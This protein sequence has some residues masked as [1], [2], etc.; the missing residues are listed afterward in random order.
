MTRPAVPG[1]AR[2]GT[3]G[4]T[5]PGTRGRARLTAAAL[6]VGAVAL[7]GAGLAAAPA[8]AAPAAAPTGWVR[9]G[10]LSPDTA[11]VD[12][13]L[14]PYGQR[15]TSILRK[16][17]Y[18]T[19]TPYRDLPQGFYTVAM[20][21]AGAAADA[22][23]MLTANVRVAP[24][25]AYTV[26]ALGRQA[27]LRANVLTDDLTPPAAG[28]A[29]VRLIQAATTATSVD[30]VAVGGPVIAKDVQYGTATGYAEVP[31]GRW[32]L[33]VSAAMQGR[34]LGSPTLDLRAGAV[35]SL[36]V[37]NRP[38]GTVDV[39]VMVDGSSMTAMPRGGVETGAGGTAAAAGG[40]AAGP[41][42]RSDRSA[43][44]LAL[45]L[46]ALLLAGLVLAGPARLARPLVVSLREGRR[47]AA[48]AD[49]GQ[50]RW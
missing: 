10:H 19:L 30:V 8:A 43:L 38:G 45:L 24:G 22:P 50:H 29:R 13:Y 5:R 48:A 31:E 34:A 36:L 3:R 15:A 26:V 42:T 32:T 37:V 12:I 21:E 27:E 47:A 33:Q 41:S 35:H 9:L 6:A 23:P 14:S 17:A 20:R 2:P 1:P 18:G 40:A 11:A 4:P 28:K 44:L 16:S 49:A 39:R 46:P 7:V 25:K